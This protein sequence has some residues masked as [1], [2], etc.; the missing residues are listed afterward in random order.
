M[1]NLHLLCA[2]TLFGF[3]STSGCTEQTKTVRDLIWVWGNPGMAEEGKHDVSSFAQASPAA[4]ARIL[5][6][7][8]VI[9]AGH[10]LPPDEVR[11]EEITKEVAGFPHLVWE[12]ASDEDSEPPAFVYRKTIDRLGKLTSHY[13]NIEG[14]LLD[15]MS[16]LGIDHGFKPEHIR[17]VRELVAE[18]C[19][20][21]DVWGV[22]Y[23][24]NFD[25]EGIEDYIRELDVL[26]LWTWHAEDIPDLEK[27]VD[28]CR[29]MFPDKPI[30]LGLYLYDYGPNRRM[31]LDLL[32]QQCETAL[33][34]TET[35]VVH[36]MVFLTINNDAD[37]VGWAAD[38]IKRVGDRKLSPPKRRIVLE[39]VD[40]PAKGETGVLGFTIQAPWMDGSIELRFPETL[41]SSLGLHFIDHVRSDMPPLHPPD[42]FPV[43]RDNLVTGEL[44]YRY[45]TED[46]LE[47]C[48]HATPGTEEVDLEFSVK[49]AT[50]KP[51]K[52][53]ASQMCLSLA[54][55]NDLCQKNDL[56]STY[57]WI[58]GT[59]TELSGTT[60]TPEEKERDP[61]IL[62]LTEQGSSQ[63]SESRDYGD[64]WWVV[65]QVAD[66]DIVAR[67]SLDGEHLVAIA[68]DDAP[69]YLMTNTRIPCLHAGPTSGTSVSLKPGQQAV[70]RGKIFLVKNDPGLL[71]DRYLAWKKNHTGPGI[72]SNK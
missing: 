13:H 53:I 1:K 70:W 35:G 50:G 48:G 59:Y 44:A 9:L 42:P 55:S 20:G 23:T 39:P 57:A 3:F 68:W 14:I 52:G 46:G 30:V 45:T 37:T 63:Y 17:N 64:G 56:S 15:D 22:V 19:P 12:V 72:E 49:N 11:A 62:L 21:I 16:S 54:G 71:L 33:K 38:W 31:P 66:H 36:G 29:Q 51:L 61:W 18:T 41:N 34:L 25:R 58:D 67:K 60:P 10:G 27:N 40:P 24:M 47:V 6:V 7:S 69:L 65:D 43:W 26:N 28:H 5:G 8:N 32:E 4:R 2:L